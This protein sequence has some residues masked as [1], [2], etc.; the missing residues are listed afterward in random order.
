MTVATADP[1]LHQQTTKKHGFLDRLSIIEQIA[2][3]AQRDTSHEHDREDAVAE[4]VATAWEWYLGLDQPS[5]APR[6]AADL[7]WLAAEIVLFCD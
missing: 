2:R 5:L 1:L 6:D 4:I 7:A 3:Y